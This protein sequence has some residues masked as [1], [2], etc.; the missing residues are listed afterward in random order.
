MEFQK[1]CQH[2]GI[3]TESRETLSKLVKF[4]ADLLLTFF[5]YKYQVS[6]ILTRLKFVM[7]IQLIASKLS[8]KCARIWMLIKCHQLVCAMFIFS[9]FFNRKSKSYHSSKSMINCRS[10]R[11][12]I[13]SV[14]SSIK[15][16]PTKPWKRSSF[17]EEFIKLRKTSLCLKGHSTF[18]V[19]HH[20]QDI[21]D[22]F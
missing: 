14:I 15:M 7:T 10:W 2:L 20:L 9:C 22:Y 3:F 8:N 1:V 4:N 17:T 18:V 16:F 12:V 21:C 19:I 5:S 6:G 13:K 11:S